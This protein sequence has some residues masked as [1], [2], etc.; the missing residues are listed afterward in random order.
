MSAVA[1][2][3][4]RGGAAWLL[5][6]NRRGTRTAIW[7]VLFLYPTFGLLDFLLAPRS[8]LP[9]LLGVR[10]FVSFTSLA[11]FGVLRS[12][13]FEANADWIAPAYIE[14]GASGIT[15]IRKTRLSTPST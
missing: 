5:A 1:S 7:L 3:V 13:A 12:R 11:M 15:Y 6:R 14:L 2:D 8:A 10:A 9:V 4:E